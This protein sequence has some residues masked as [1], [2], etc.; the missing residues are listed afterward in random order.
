M[1]SLSKYEDHFLMTPFKHQ[2]DGVRALLDNENFGLFDGMGVGKSAQVVSAAC[3]LA[4][5]G[6]IDTVLIVSPA[7]VRSVWTNEDVDLGE[8]AKHAWASVD[9]MEFYS[10]SQKPRPSHR[11]ARR[12]PLPDGSGRKFDDQEPSGHPN[13]I[14]LPDRS[15]RL[16][17][18]HPQRHTDYELSW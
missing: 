18:G 7:S 1:I 12:A 11:G 14:L 17:A 6:L 5:E 2:L 16:P 8:I 9:V 4:Q 3:I 15:A 13:Q 10:T